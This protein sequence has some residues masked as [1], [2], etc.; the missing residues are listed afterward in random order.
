MS[1]PGFTA[2]ASLG[3][4]GAM[5]SHGVGGKSQRMLPG[6]PIVLA[7]AYPQCDQYTGCALRA[8]MCVAGGDMWIKC[9][10]GDHCSCGGMCL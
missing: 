1:L 5:G 3:G 2:E 9:G 8:C 4:G 6:S 7:S 10:R